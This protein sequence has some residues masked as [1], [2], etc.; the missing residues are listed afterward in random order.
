[1]SAETA[2]MITDMLVSAAESGVGGISVSGTEIAAKSGTSNVDRGWAEENG[3]PTSA[4]RDAWN[5]TY[6]PEYAIAL[7]IGYDKTTSDSYLTVSVGNKARTGIMKAVGSK[8]YSKNKA[9]TVPSGVIE[10]EVEKETFP[11][12]LA[13]EYTPNDMRMTEL[14]K[15]GTEPTDVSTRY[16]KLDAPTKGSYTFDGTTLKL[17]WTGIETPDT[18]DTSYLQNHF[19]TYYG[20]QAS[21]YY[22]QRIS[23]NNSN[24]GKLEYKIYKKE[25]D[26]TLTL[27]GS[28]S[29]LNYT[30]NP[31]ETG[32][33]TYVIKSSY[34]IFTANMSD[35]LE[36]KVNLGMDSNIDDIITPD[37]D[38]D[39]INTDNQNKPDTGL[40]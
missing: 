36:I 2:Y 9:F 32:E 20:N 37:D 22:E 33:V 35:G 27:V 39:D 30:I 21:K 14:F 38:T 1:M 15:N 40:E 24:I 11:L 6:S 23:Y 17:S 25:S 18:I 26:G 31:T 10:V 12:Q 28:T 34:T 16:S 7:W 19:N 8:V 3:I 4:T 29:N 5:I 13:S